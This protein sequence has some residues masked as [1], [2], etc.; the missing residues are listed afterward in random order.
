MIQL[1][2]L[3]MLISGLWDIF[4]ASKRI[5]KSKLGVGETVEIASVKIKRRGKN[6]ILRAMVFFI[7]SLFLPQIVLLIHY[8]IGWFYN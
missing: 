3:L 7:I 1:G 8:V 4:G 5:D 2:A 6:S